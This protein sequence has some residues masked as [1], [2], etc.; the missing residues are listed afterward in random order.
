VSQSERRW[1]GEENGAIK[2]NVNNWIGEIPMTDAT[3]VAIDAA[4]V[5]F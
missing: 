5:Y 2:S 4:T 3:K 1:I